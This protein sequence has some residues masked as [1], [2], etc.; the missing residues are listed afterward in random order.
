[1]DLVR[2]IAEVRE[3]VR[4]ARL[5]ERTVVFVPTMGYLHEGHLSLVDRARAH[6]GSFV[7]V[8]IFVNPSQFGNQMDLDTYPRDEAR[9]LELLEQRGADL[10]FIPDASEIYPAGFT[11]RVQVGGVSEPL[12]GEHR[13]GHFDGVATVVAK[14]FNIVQPEIAI[15]GRKDAQQC[16]VV[17]RMVRDLDFPVVIEIG[18]TVREADGLAMSSRNVRLDRNAREA[19]LALSRALERGRDLLGSGAHRDAIEEEMSAMVESTGA[20]VEYLRVVDSQTFRTP[21]SSSELLIVGAVRVGEVR[22]IDNMEAERQLK[23]GVS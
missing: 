23:R 2:S 11:T 10:A 4:Q 8:S 19:S 14:L 22:L 1:M 21:D 15:F 17:R 7:V 12:E 5:A 13:P 20:E 6:T 16:A 18:E 3:W 9:D